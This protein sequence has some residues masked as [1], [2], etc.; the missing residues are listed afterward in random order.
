MR[1]LRDLTK[2][3][4]PIIIASHLKPRQGNKKPSN[5]DLFGSSNISKE[6]KTVILM[7]REENLTRVQ[8][9]KNRDGGQ[10]TDVMASFNPISKELEFDPAFKNKDAF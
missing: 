1:A 10:T 9:T 5:Y 8:I 7:S 2:K 3:N 6:A 4:I